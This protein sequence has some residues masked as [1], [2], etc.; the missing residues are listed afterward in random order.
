MSSNEDC[1]GCLSN[2]LIL[3]S[4]EQA[5]KTIQR[6]TSEL[7]KQKKIA[8]DAVVGRY[9]LQEQLQLERD[10]R[11]HDSSENRAHEAQPIES[12]ACVKGKDVGYA[13]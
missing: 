1:S 4:L 11:N 6:L 3:Q 8:A 7:S 13:N 5:T 10:W 2:A 9:A 12:T